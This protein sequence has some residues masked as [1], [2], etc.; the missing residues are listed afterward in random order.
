LRHGIG[1]MWMSI[2]G[3]SLIPLLDPAATAG[4]RGGGFMAKDTVYSLFLRGVTFFV[5]KESNQRKSCEIE[6]PEG[7]L[8]KAGSGL[9]D[10]DGTDYTLKEA[11]KSQILFVRPHHGVVS[12][13]RTM[14]DRPAA[15]PKHRNHET[16]V[17][18]L[19]MCIAIAQSSVSLMHGTDKSN[20]MRR[21]TEITKLVCAPQLSAS[22]SRKA[23]FCQYP[24]GQTFVSISRTVF[25][26]PAAVT[27]EKSMPQDP[28]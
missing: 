8:G 17:C 7:R 15:Q 27:E 26:R 9:R 4:F 18:P 23:R 11:S 6:C 28:F 5:T 19:T 1:R 20:N 10:F 2:S 24:I 21:S 14:C 22:R 12:I 25:D 3:G 16:C 13:S